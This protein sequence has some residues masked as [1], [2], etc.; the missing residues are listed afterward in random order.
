MGMEQETAS[1]HEMMGSWEGKE[2]REPLVKFEGW[3][4]KKVRLGGEENGVSPGVGAG[5]IEM[6]SAAAMNRGSEADD[7]KVTVGGWEGDAREE[8]P[9]DPA[10]IAGFGSECDG[11]TEVPH[12]VIGSDRG[13]FDEGGK[14]TLEETLP[15]YLHVSGWLDASAHA[16]VMAFMTLPCRCWLL[17]G[18]AI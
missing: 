15:Y 9:S 16:A 13:V 6:T 14:G 5:E 4:E 3:E 1:S 10:F 12:G 18:L 8:V 2:D 7:S 11:K 17:I